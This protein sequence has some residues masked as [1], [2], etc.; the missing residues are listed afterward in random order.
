[1]SVNSTRSAEDA[2]I[3][4]AYGRIAVLVDRWE[5]RTDLSAMERRGEE[6]KA[7]LFLRGEEQ[8]VYISII[9]NNSSRME[10]EE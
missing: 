10:V 7:Q 1:M 9:M 8:Q 6:R 2:K 4:L 5:S 3:I